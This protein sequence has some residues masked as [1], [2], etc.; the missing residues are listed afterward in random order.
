MIKEI[1]KPEEPPQIAIKF[2]NMVFMLGILY[3]IL[4]LA[5]P[6]YRILTLSEIISPVFYISSILCGSLFTILFSLGIKKLRNNLKVNL[7]ILLF[8]IGITVYGFETIL[9]YFYKEEAQWIFSREEAA[10]EMGLPFDTR[11]KIK[12]LADLKKFGI[13]ALPNTY[14]ADFRVS[15]GLSTKEG[16]IYPLGTISNSMTVFCN[17]N[18]F[19]SIYES[20]EYGFN[21][22]KGLY[23]ENKVDVMLTGD[24]FTEGA[25]V[26]P[27][28]TISAV[29]R[30]LNLNVINV[31][32]ASNGSLAELAA[33]RE[34]AKPLKPRIVLWL[35]YPGDFWDL[36][37]EME[38]SIL[39]KYLDEDNYSQNLISRQEEI[40]R[41]LMNYI[42]V[43]QEKK[44][45]TKNKNHTMNNVRDSTSLIIIKD[46]II[47][48]LKLTRLRMMIN[49]KPPQKV[50][51]FKNVLSKSNQMVLDWGGKM[52]FVYL[53]GFQR[54]AT[55]KKHENHDL[56]IEIATKLDIP[57]I[58]IHKEVFES[59][60]DPLSLFP[61]R[62]YGHYNIEGYRL[63]SEAIGKKL[64]EDGYAPTK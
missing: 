53:P 62:Q 40:D 26:K 19:W 29:L 54:Y 63:V 21:N 30:Q 24:S 64:T 59:H 14:P 23:K 18:G 43:E 12:I 27:N 49:L 1:N 57:V 17:E 31:G 41:V 45:M 56:V 42:K 46:L 33:L 51:L 16:R 5:F 60:D 50:S 10:K 55:G 61:F 37:N 35:F 22:P 32:K 52:I 38:S 9:E 2:A 8:T 47:N 25:C 4:L 13:E 15:N 6:I 58:D 11:S 39:R 28:D 44:I 7:S 48:I 36:S 34:Y 20:D 3:S